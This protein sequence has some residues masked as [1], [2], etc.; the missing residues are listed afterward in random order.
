M[1]EDDDGRVITFWV[2]IC[3]CL[4]RCD[5]GLQRCST[6]S[7]MIVCSKCWA[8][9]T[10]TACA[11]V[12]AVYDTRVPSEYRWCSPCGRLLTDSDPCFKACQV[13]DETIR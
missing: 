12:R 4:C 10:A 7:N 6:S 8:A 11:A 5:L 2:R 9:P 13:P 3:C 1:V